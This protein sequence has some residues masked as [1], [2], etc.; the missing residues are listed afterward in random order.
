MIRALFDTNVLVSA[1]IKPSGTPGRALGL[2]AQGAFELFLSE[3]ILDE[4]AAVL[5]RPYFLRRLG[6]PLV[7]PHFVD[8]LAGSFPLAPPLVE[9]DHVVVDPDDDHVVAAALACQAHFLVTGDKKHLLPLRKVENT[10][11]VSVS[12]FLSELGV[13]A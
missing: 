3:R 6:D 4:L 2:A 8:L 10:K 1:L 12:E 5:Q 11:V 7:I 13:D 9:T